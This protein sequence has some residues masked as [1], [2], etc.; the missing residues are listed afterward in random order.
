[1]SRIK[2][3]KAPQEEGSKS[4]AGSSRSNIGKNTK[5]RAWTWIVY[6]EQIEQVREWLERSPDIAWALSPKHTDDRNPDGTEKK[7]HWHLC[8]HFSS[9]T[10][11]YN[12]V[13]GIS[14][15]MGLPVPQVCRN[16]RGMVRYFLHLDNPEKAQY[17]KSDITAGGGFDV[18][19]YLKLSQSEEEF[20][21][22]NF[23]AKLVNRCVEKGILY[24]HEVFDLVMSEY[25]ED[26][27][28]FRKN[29]YLV[30]EYLYSVRNFGEIVRTTEEQQPPF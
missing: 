16:T 12:V 5:S 20:E 8:V 11:T 22:R 17:T 13:K 27:Q 23:L 9:G 15:E 25:P 3:K 26:F 21:M 1:M 10:T 24:F 19:E 30:K 7:P 29:T 28:Y 6:E 14:D 4:F 18:E 2:I